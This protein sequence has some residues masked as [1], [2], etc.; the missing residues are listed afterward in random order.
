MPAIKDFH[1][2]QTEHR[3]VL[4]NQLESASS[5]GD[6]VEVLLLLPLATFIVVEVLLRLIG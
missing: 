3:L 4:P 6:W 2:W 1:Q 5:S